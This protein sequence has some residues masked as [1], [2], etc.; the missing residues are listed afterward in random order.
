[1]ALYSQHIPGKNNVIADSL[2][3]DLHVPDKKL[4][5]LLNN[6]Y[7][8]QTQNNLRLTVPSKEIIC[9]IYSLKDMKTNRE[10]YQVIRTPSSLGHL[11]G[12]DDSWKDVVSKMNSWMALQESREPVSCPHL[13]QVLESISMERQTRD[14]FAKELS[15]P[16]LATFVRPSGRTF[17]TTHL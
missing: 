17:V 1:M 9:L 5:F 16:P 14:N 10:E 3:R 7:P 12:G 4:T 11:I 13:Q 15:V 2:S 6:L 8:L